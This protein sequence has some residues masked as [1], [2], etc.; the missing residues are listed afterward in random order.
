MKQ[1]MRLYVQG[2]LESIEA[3]EECTQP[4]NEKEFYNRRQVQDAV[5]RRLE[6]IGEAVKKID[7]KFRNKHSDIPIG[8]RLQE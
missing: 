3:I 6:I 1:D 8:R 4:L 5:V 2:I 7:E